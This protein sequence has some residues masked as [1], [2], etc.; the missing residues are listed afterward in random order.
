M[1][2]TIRGTV[3]GPKAS[4]KMYPVASRLSPDHT[5]EPDAAFS[6]VMLTVVAVVALLKLVYFLSLRSS[7][8][9]LSSPEGFCLS[10][11]RQQAEISSNRAGNWSDVSVCSANSWRGFNLLILLFVLEA[12]L[13]GR[14]NY[15]RPHNIK[16]KRKLGGNLKTPWRLYRLAR[17]CQGFHSLP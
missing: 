13:V 4:M 3:A 10:W 15:I 7:P 2:G 1:Q 6:F 16:R 9:L 8:L 5:A 12:A 11:H 14:I 17:G